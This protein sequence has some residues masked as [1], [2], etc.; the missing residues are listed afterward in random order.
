MEVESLGTSTFVELVSKPQKSNIELCIICQK[1]RNSNQNTNLTSTHKGRDAVN[2]TSRILSDD[3]LY[4]LNETDLNKIQYHVKT[5]YTRYKKAE[6]KWKECIV[7]ALT[8]REFPMRP[9]D[10]S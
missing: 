2:K 7:K 6:Q 3:T 5:C 8:Y 4:R 9:N 1:V 10:K